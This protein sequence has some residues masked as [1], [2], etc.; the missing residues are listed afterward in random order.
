MDSFLCSFE[1][2]PILLES[3]IY[4]QYVTILCFQLN[5]NIGVQGVQTR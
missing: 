3:V 4:S 5:I 2:T 1:I